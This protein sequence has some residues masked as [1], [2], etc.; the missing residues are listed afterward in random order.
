MVV[1]QPRT[2][3]IN[4]PKGRTIIQL[5]S[6]ENL[7]STESPSVCNT[8]TGKEALFSF[9]KVRFDYITKILSYGR[10]QET[11]FHFM[12]CLVVDS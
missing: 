8:P 11:C 7:S 5:Q 4:T 2:R 6:N 1:G 3:I 9:N 10:R 12:L